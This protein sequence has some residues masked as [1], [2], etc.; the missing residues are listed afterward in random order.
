MYCAI[1]YQ[2]VCSLYNILHS[3]YTWFYHLF[4]YFFNLCSWLHYWNFYVDGPALWLSK[5]NWRVASRWLSEITF[6]GFSPKKTFRHWPIVTTAW[7]LFSAMV[8]SALISF[9]HPPPQENWRQIDGIDGHACLLSS[10]LVMYYACS[11]CFLQWVSMTY[12]LIS[13]NSVNVLNYSQ[14]L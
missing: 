12:V 7:F 5:H 9:L 4:L 6:I 10:W 3:A 14:C 11:F 2:F 1:G 8:A 13:N